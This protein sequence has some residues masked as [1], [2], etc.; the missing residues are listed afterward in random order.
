[1]IT[2]NAEIH[3]LRS[4]IARFGERVVRPHLDSL[5]HYPDVPLPAGIL[6]GLHE[7]GL[8]DLG[9]AAARPEDASTRILL[10]AA[11]AALAET[12]AAPAALLFAH[13]VAHA[14]VAAAGT[15]ARPLGTEDG[16]GS[17][18]A[19]WAYPVYGDPADPD[20]EAVL[21]EGP[22]AVVLDG[23]CELVVNAPVAR[24]LVVPARWGD[25]SGEPALVL[26]SASAPGVRVGEA[27]LTL[28]MRGCPVADVSFAGVEL[29]AAAVVARGEAVAH[30]ARIVRSALRGAALAIAGAVLR[31]SILA[32]AMYARDRYQGGQPILQHQ[33]VRAMLAD[34]LADH[35]LC[36]SAVEVLTRSD[37][38]PEAM[39]ACLF[40]RARDAVTRAA[41][42]GVQLLGGY[43]YMEDYEQERRMRDARQ[44]ACLLGRGDALRQGLVA[45]W[46][47]QGQ[48]LPT[49]FEPT[50]VASH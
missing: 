1:M 24:H 10:V 15:D 11:L 18:P 5:N 25:A 45:D 31:S 28:G 3:V 50:H 2:D 40:V 26:V 22:G 43:G 49:H 13:A 37:P 14:L 6:S 35:A 23:A 32:A 20:T 7:L 21:R 17:E 42:D 19:V 47:D 48:D 9:A 46:L 16:R 38:V 34:M 39:A 8:F 12:A 44:A 4:S 41:A 36:H 29:D 33:Q 30:G 27:L